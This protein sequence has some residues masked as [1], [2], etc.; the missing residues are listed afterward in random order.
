M[1]AQVIDA[2]GAHSRMTVGQALDSAQSA[3][4]TECI[5]IGYGESG[6]LVVRSSGMT[7]R[8]ALWILEQARLHTLEAA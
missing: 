2:F 3:G 5:V 4:L 8:D 7:R 6:D 1:T